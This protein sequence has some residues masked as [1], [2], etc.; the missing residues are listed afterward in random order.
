MKKRLKS[1]YPIIVR[2]IKME[3]F[4]ECFFDDYKHV[5]VIRINRESDE[6]VAVDT[7]LHEAAHILAFKYKP[8][9]GNKWGIA[10]SKIY[11]EYLRLFTC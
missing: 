4:G 8:Y 2:R 3:D 1:K 7:F 6:D 9:H 5:F 10:Y 11:R